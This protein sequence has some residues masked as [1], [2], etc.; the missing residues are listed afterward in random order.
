MRPRNISLIHTHSISIHIHYRDSMY[1]CIPGADSK[2]Q[3]LFGREGTAFEVE[4]VVV[5]ELHHVGARS[6]C[7][8]TSGYMYTH[9]CVCVYVCVCVCVLYISKYRNMK[10]EVYMEF[11]RSAL[12]SIHE[13]KIQIADFRYHSHISIMTCYIYVQSNITYMYIYI[14]ISSNEKLVGLGR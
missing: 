4:R 3:D 9:V 7:Q 12:S 2:S 13:P 11:F 8:K 14:S 10:D 5:S 6:H 1:V